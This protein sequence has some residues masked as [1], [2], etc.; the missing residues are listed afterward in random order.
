[1]HA[2]TSRLFANIFTFHQ[3][4]FS[5]RKKIYTS[6]CKGTSY[7][8]WTFAVQSPSSGTAVVYKAYT[9]YVY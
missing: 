5:K 6:I 4:G 9:K 3:N 1:M 8:F 2:R 7:N